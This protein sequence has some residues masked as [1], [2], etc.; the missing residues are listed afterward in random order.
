MR[1]KQRLFDMC[2]Q[3]LFCSHARCAREQFS[4]LCASRF[5]AN[6]LALGTSILSISSE[7]VNQ[8]HIAQSRDMQCNSVL[9]RLIANKL[10]AVCFACKELALINVQHFNLAYSR[11]HIHTAQCR[12][13][14]EQDSLLSRFRRFRCSMEQR[15]AQSACT[16]AQH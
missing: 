13:Y 3:F 1:S 9:L 14:I 2:K 11:Q 15:A 8:E 16:H 4:E 7:T 10:D 6:A 12:V 5:I